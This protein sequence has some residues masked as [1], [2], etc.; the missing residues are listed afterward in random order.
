MIS[1]YCGEI[2]IRVLIFFKIISDRG[3]DNRRISNIEQEISNNEVETADYSQVVLS[4][5]G[6]GSWA[7][8]L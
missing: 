2:I 7:F 6:I 4:V 3:A 5:P 8:R 1:D